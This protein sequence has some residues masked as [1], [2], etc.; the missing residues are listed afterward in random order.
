MPS[1]VGCGLGLFVDS[2]VVTYLDHAA[3]TAL[4]PLAVEALA[5]ESQSLGNA[6]AVHGAGRAARRVVEESRELLAAR[7]GADPVEV[8]LTGGGTEADNLAVKGLFWSR[9]ASEPQ[10]R[11]VLVSAVEHHAVLDP[12]LWLAERAGAVVVQLPVDGTGRVDPDALAAE[13][14]AHP[15]E[16]ALVAVMWANNEVGTVQPVADVVELAH[17]YDVPVHV[18]AVQ[19]AG[20]LPVSFAASGADTM[21]V[22]GHKIGGPVGIGAL[23]VRRGLELTPVLHGGGQER[24]MRSGTVPVALARSFAVAV[25]VAVA[26]QPER[27]EHMSGLRDRLVAGVLA[28]IPDAVVRGPWPPGQDLSTVRDRLPGN[29]HL[30][31][32]GCDGEALTLLLDDAGVHASTGSACQAGVAR[33][34]HVLLAMG[35]PDAVARGALR[36]SFGTSSTGG[37]V[38]AVLRVLPGVVERAR[39]VGLVR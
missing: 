5:A 9:T 1:V 31:F 12:A 4:H 27:A 3:T 20:Q 33:P 35:V 38:D 37:D 6:S 19:A 24:R 18:D 23:V 15:D 25:D 32:P 26:E 14:A 28:S 34:S 36:F 7:L 16:V 17:R 30:T 2:T 13:L 21:A 8:V 22:S 39:A 10:R 29:A 11:R